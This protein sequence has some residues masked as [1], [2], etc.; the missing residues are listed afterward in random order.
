MLYPI[1]SLY[2][3]VCTLEHTCRGGGEEAPILEIFGI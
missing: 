2:S 1:I 3:C